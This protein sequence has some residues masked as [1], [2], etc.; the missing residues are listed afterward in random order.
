MSMRRGKKQ[1]LGSSC[2]SSSDDEAVETYKGDKGRQERKRLQD[3]VKELQESLDVKTKE[4]V[5]VEED[6]K[7][8][9][10]ERKKLGEE[11]NTVE[12]VKIKVQ[13]D[14]A[15]VEEEK[16]KVKE[17]TA[18][19]EENRASVKKEMAKVAHDQLEVEQAKLMVEEDRAKAEE[20]ITEMELMF[21]E[22][23]GLVECPVCL[24]LPRED[25]PVPCCPQGHLVCSPCMDKLT[26]RLAKGFVHTCIFLMKDVWK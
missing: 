10:E 25:K 21:E 26:I 4:A 20:E 18:K 24:A 14:R 11:K 9:E 16:T 13:E 5:K 3:L 12:R 23:L 15:N 19:V 17:E 7:Q 1:K 2:E 8:L 22:Q 6:K